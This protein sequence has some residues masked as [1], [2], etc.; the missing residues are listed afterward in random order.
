MAPDFSEKDFHIHYS[1]HGSSRSWLGRNYSHLLVNGGPNLGLPGPSPAFPT[2]ARCWQ[3]TPFLFAQLSLGLGLH[4]RAQA[5]STLKGCLMGAKWVS[6]HRRVPVG[7]MCSQT[8]VKGQDQNQYWGFPWLQNSWPWGPRSFCD[9]L[10]QDTYLSTQHP[11]CSVVP[12]GEQVP[13][14][15]LHPGGTSSPTH[16]GCLAGRGPKHPCPPPGLQLG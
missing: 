7:W 15:G 1:H 3:W 11:W 14:G 10:S 2:A 5:L 8:Q 9:A 12:S 6:A 13:Q 4:G 16:Y